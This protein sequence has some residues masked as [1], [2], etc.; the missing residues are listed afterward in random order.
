MTVAHRMSANPMDAILSYDCPSITS[1]SQ[2]VGLLEEWV[3]EA[4]D[5]ALE[6]DC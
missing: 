5:S 3:D 1:E 4:H 2:A 6:M